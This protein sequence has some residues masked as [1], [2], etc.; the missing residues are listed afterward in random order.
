MKKLFILFTVLIFFVLYGCHK[1]EYHPVACFKVENST[2][3]LGDTIKIKVCTSGR[4]KL[5]LWMM[6]DGVTYELSGIPK[7]VYQAK[8]TYVIKLRVTEHVDGGQVF[9]WQKPTT[10]EAEQTVTVQ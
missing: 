8:G 9:H 10:S 2:M 4:S 6:G 3:I 1:A 5:N 7:H